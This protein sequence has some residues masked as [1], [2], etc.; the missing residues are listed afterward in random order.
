MK[1]LVRAERHDRI[2]SAS[3]RET[4]LKH[5]PRAWKVNLILADNPLGDDLYD[6]LV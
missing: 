3:Q 2:G 4:N 1:R 5:W 6:R